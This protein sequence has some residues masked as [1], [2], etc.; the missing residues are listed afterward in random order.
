MNKPLATGH[1][2]AQKDPATAMPEDETIF[3][4]EVPL[5]AEAEALVRA[6]HGWSAAFEKRA[7]E[8]SIALFGVTQADT[9]PPL[10]DQSAFYKGRSLDE[11]AYSAAMEK[12]DQL[13]SD[14]W[15]IESDKAAYDET[16]TWWLEEADIYVGGDDER[17]LRCLSFFERQL[18]AAAFELLPGCC[19]TLD[20]TGTRA[21]QSS[22]AWGAA[23]AA[24]AEKYLS[25]PKR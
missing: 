5:I 18:N 8:I 22:E 23:L 9:F 6:G 24:D 3:L 12:L 20:G 14:L 2:N 21:A 19:L 7:D 13:Q 17:P 4:S 10:P 25:R 1:E 16:I 15:T 11:A